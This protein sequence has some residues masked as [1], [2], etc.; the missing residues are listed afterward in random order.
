MR[1]YLNLCFF[2]SFLFPTK[3]KSYL[4]FPTHPLGVLDFFC[5]R[6]FHRVTSG[7]LQK[8]WICFVWRFRW[9]LG[10]WDLFI[11]WSGCLVKYLKTLNGWDFFVVKWLFKQL[12]F[13]WCHARVAFSTIN[14]WNFKFCVLKFKLIFDILKLNLGFD[15]FWRIQEIVMPILFF[16][17][18]KIYKINKTYHRVYEF[19][20]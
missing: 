5:L 18:F 15:C 16:I 3:Q 13:V 12:S 19:E 9:H 1:F 14:F 2:I 20:N 8:Y 17:G 4:K 7:S 10:W 6:L 11:F